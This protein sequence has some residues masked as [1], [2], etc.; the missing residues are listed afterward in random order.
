MV[1]E[2]KTYETIELYEIK[3]THTAMF[4]NNITYDIIIYMHEILCRDKGVRPS[5]LHPKMAMSEFF[6]KSKCNRVELNSLIMDFLDVYIDFNCY[7][8]FNQ[9]EDLIL[10]IRMNISCSSSNRL[11]VEM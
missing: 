11:Q 7:E 9:L 2:G 6:D 1:L 10:H 4:I 3:S 5:E 8:Y